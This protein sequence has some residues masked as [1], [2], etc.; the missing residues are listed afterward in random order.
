[1]K[2]HSTK[3]SDRFRG[4]GSDVVLHA[5]AQYLR[6]EEKAIRGGRIEAFWTELTLA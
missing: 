2:I 5:S 3:S 4:T 1:M 6:Y